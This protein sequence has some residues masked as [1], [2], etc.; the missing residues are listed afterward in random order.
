MLARCI[1][2]TFLRYSSTISPL[3]H[4]IYPT[5]RS[6]GI[7]LQNTLEDAPGYYSHKPP[8]KYTK[9][10][11]EVYNKYLSK[12]PQDVQSLLLNGAD[13]KIAPN[14]IKND[15]YKSLKKDHHHDE[16][17]IECQRCRDVIY[18]S[19]IKLS[20]PAA[21]EFPMESLDTVV[22]KYVPV[23]G[24]VVYVV[25]MFDFP[26]SINTDIF[27][28]RKPQEV[29]FVVTKSDLA[30]KNNST[31]IKYGLQFV[32]DYLLRK[33]HV[34]PKNVII[35]SAVTEW[36]I[37]QLDEF[38]PDNAYFIGNVNCGKSLLLK[39][40][41][42]HEDQKKPT[43]QTKK[44][45]LHAEKLEDYRISGRQKSERYLSNAVKKDY[46]K[47]FKATNGPGVSY[48]PGF[49]RGPIPISLGKKTIYDVAGFIN[50]SLHRSH[51]YYKMVENP[52]VFKAINKGAP[53]HKHGTFESKYET[54]RSQRCVS[55]GGLLFIEFPENSMYQLRNC[56]NHKVDIFRNWDRMYDVATNLEAHENFRDNFLI[57]HSKQLFENLVR[58]VIPPFY[59]IVDL[60]VQ[61]LGHI[62][63]KPTGGKLTNDLIV[64]YA[65]PG[66]EMVIRQP[67]TNY[68]AKSFTQRDKRGNPLSKEKWVKESTLALK[69]YSGKD[70]FYSR[71]IKTENNGIYKDR[72]KDDFRAVSQFV[73]VG[74]G[75]KTTYN[76]NLTIT[77]ENQYTYWVE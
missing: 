11:D 40:L 12:V 15:T 4:T 74:K 13:H 7:K 28:H 53:I 69:R 2:R 19:K 67:I 27:K 58:Y 45:K 16:P 18:R 51:E 61:G 75:I 77:A 71:L 76:E 68:I 49:T 35:L 56:I 50:L 42:F 66:L 1:G 55:V 41:L 62:N 30:F 29:R 59:G 47:R 3:L 52:A 34:P 21:D 57:K 10:E 25:N 43:Y 36:D 24:N 31:A 70:A 9:P 14:L 44:E 17:S 72:Q 73:L 26:I 33:Y 6:C 22:E 60:V 63:L 23:D 20:T 64:V 8:K 5:C 65:V 54:V 46:E 37:L 32:Q 48:V 38:I 39:S